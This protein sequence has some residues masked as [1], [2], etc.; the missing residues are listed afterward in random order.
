M[1]FSP[2]LESSYVPWVTCPGMQLPRGPNQ[3]T[4]HQLILY[5]PSPP[6]WI[7]HL[8]LLIWALKLSLINLLLFISTVSSLVGD[9]ISFTLTTWI[10]FLKVSLCSFSLLLIASI[11]LTAVG[12]V[13]KMQVWL[14]DS[15][16]SILLWL[17]T[18]LDVSATII[19]LIRSYWLTASSEPSLTTVFALWT[20][21]TRALFVF[22]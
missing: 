16:N 21:T 3:R 2:R 8:V 10:T 20:P 1:T 9:T 4:G 22:L 17:A 13:W 7:S 14:C 11:F 5:P 12:V 15:S 6:W 18:V 19:I